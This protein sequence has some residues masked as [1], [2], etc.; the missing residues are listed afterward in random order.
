M[1]ENTLTF[2]EIRAWYQRY[3]DENPDLNI[4]V[5]KAARADFAFSRNPTV[6]DLVE[7]D[8]RGE[9]EYTAIDDLDNGAAP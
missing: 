9:L 7:K 1:S 5:D 4:D 3:A 6:I 8:R 2:E